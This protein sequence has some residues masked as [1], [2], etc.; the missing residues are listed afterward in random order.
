MGVS[1][2]HPSPS[3]YDIPASSK[4]MVV[5]IPDPSGARVLDTR[6]IGDFLLAIVEYPDADNYEGRKILVYKGVT[7]R[8]LRSWAKIDPH[9]S[10]MCP[11]RSPIARFVPTPEGERMAELFCRSMQ[12]I[13]DMVE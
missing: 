9:F 12:M 6:K 8:Q 13:A 7:S 1:P 5:I 10:K 3:T 4:P 11:Q 2:F